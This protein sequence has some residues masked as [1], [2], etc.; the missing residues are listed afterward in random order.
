MKRI[1]GAMLA[2]A[3]LLGL[4]ISVLTSPVA[5]AHDLPGIVAEQTSVPPEVWAKIDEIRTLRRFLAQEAAKAKS[6]D[7][8]VESV[9]DLSATWPS[10]RVSVCFLDGGID[11]RVRVAEVARRWMQST[12]LQ[13]DFGPAD[14]PRMCEATGPSNIRVTF[15]GLGAR[16]FVGKEAKQVPAGLPTMTLGQMDKTVFTEEEDATILHEFGHAIGFQHEHQSPASVCNDEFNWDFLYKKMAAWG[17]NRAK[18]DHNMRRLA[19]STRLATTSFDPESIM[20]YNLSRDFFRTDIATLSCFI[21]NKNTAI[22]KT[23][24]EAAATV[25]PAAVSMRSLLPRKR[26]LFAPKRDRDPAV[27]QAIKRLKELTDTK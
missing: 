6:E 10:R 26:G 4:A 25:Y 21:P 19:P 7:F 2:S 5:R 14:N 23:D 1:F 9:I 18:V 24:R 16:S 15:V 8:E 22:S 12:G 3:G 11:A 20:L 27:T 17:W 13:L